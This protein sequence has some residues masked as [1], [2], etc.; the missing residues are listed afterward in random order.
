VFFLRQSF[1]AALGFI[2]NIAGLTAEQSLDSR[3]S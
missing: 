2:H 3:S 1:F